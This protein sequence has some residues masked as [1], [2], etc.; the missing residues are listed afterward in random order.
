[1]TIDPTI[2]CPNCRHEIK[3]TESLAEPLLEATRSHFEA[4]LAEKDREVASK[5]EALVTERQLIAQQKRDLEATIQARAETA[6]NEIAAQEA[7]RAKLNASREIAE[8]DRSVADLKA[9]VEQQDA[10]LA[11]AQQVQADVLKKQREL[12]DEKRELALTVEKRVQENLE[13]IRLKAKAEA[14]DAMALKLRENETQMT[15]MRKTIEDLQKK[16]E[17]GSQQ[18]Q[19]EAQELELE[20]MLRARFPFDQFEPI[21]KG[22]HGADVLHRVF[23]GAGQQCGTIL[24]ESKRTRNWAND[25][26]PKL[27]KDQREARADV[28]VIISQAVP[29]DM[30]HSFDLIDE[31]WVTEP[32]CAMPIAL[33]LRETLIAVAGA[34]QASD[35]Q[36]TKA[37]LVYAY[38]I[39][40]RFRHRVQAIIEQFTT[41][42]DDLDRERRVLTKQWAKRE[43]QILTVVESTAGLYGDLQGIAGTNLEEIEALD[44]LLLDGPP[45]AG[46]ADAARRD[47]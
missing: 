36:K 41:M 11:E 24:W 28:A 26:L 43:S 7:E 23:N 1:M 9:L 32:R 4:R 18:L 12:D 47:G 29:K 2:T 35:G 25:W 19:G 39:G 22:V 15:S 45:K 3:L 13:A 42:K 6:R 30:A 14:E 10:K 44:L 20:A 37:E 38:L 5:E 27:R 8:R 31:V 16:A 33:C 17:Q 34:R 21:S 46:G 40:P